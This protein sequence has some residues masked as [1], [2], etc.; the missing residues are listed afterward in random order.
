LVT[1]FQT[2]GPYELPRK[3]G[4]S[5]VDC[6]KEMWLSINEIEQDGIAE[7]LKRAIGVYIVVREIGKNSKPWYVGKTY[8]GFNSRFRQHLKGKV[9]GGIEKIPKGGKVKI[10]LLVRGSTK[11]GKF[12]TRVKRGK[13]VKSI[14]ILEFMLI[15]S[16]QKLNPDLLNTSQAAFH[17][18]FQIPGYMNDKKSKRNPAAK[19]LAIALRVK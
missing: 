7:R 8:S 12:K 18:G 3:G 16:C 13:T 4:I 10:F 6:L 19:E 15:G 11:T 1:K 17:R 5:N 14:D 9:F 2:F